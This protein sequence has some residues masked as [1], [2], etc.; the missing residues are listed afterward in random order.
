MGQET[1]QEGNLSGQNGRKSGEYPGR[2]RV[3]VGAVVFRNRKVLLVERGKPPGQGQWSI[4]GGSVELGETL[5]QAAGREILEETGIVVRPG[6]PFFTFDVIRR[7]S[8]NAVRFHYIIVDLKAEYVSGVPRAGD[9]ALRVAWAASDDLKNL[10]VN[11]GTLE[12]LKKYF[13]FGKQ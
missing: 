1:N 10:N 2:P 5:Q 6:E 11:P 12:I 7:D 4:P 3:A 9:D 8:R 13:D